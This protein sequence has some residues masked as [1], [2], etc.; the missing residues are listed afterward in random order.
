MNPSP[1]YTDWGTAATDIQAAVDAA[2]DGDTVLVT[3]GVYAAGARDLFLWNT[4][5]S[6]PRMMSIW[7]SRVVVTNAIRLESVNGPGVTLIDG[8][9]RTNGDVVVT[10]RARCVYLGDGAVLSEA[11]P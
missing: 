5:A 11:S 8:G 4:N 2:K 9:S 7:P 1:P 3:N 6:P 10:A